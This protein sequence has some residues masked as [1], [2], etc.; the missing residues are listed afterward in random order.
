MLHSCTWHGT[1][2]TEKQLYTP[3]TREMLQPSSAAGESHRSTRLM[4][5]QKGALAAACAY[6]HTEVI[7]KRWNDGRVHAS[8]KHLP[9][10]QQLPDT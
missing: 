6:I 2:A 9:V 3:M 5:R 7:L 4:T 10:R 1:A 8:A